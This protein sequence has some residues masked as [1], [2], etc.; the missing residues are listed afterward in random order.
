MSADSNSLESPAGEPAGARSAP[1]AAPAPLLDKEGRNLPKP[2]Q[3]A[4][5]SKKQWM[6]RRVVLD[7]LQFWQ[8]SGYQ[9]L[10]V[11]L[12][13]SPSSPVAR[14]RA[15]FQ[16]LRKRCGRELGFPGFQYVCVDTREGHGVLH[17]LWAWRDPDGKK[18]ASFYV[19]FAWLQENWKDIHGAFHV[20][21]KRVGGQDTDAKRLSRYIV[22]QYCGGQDAL[23]RVSQ[24][25]R[26][27]PFS[28]MRVALRRL[29]RELPE[30]HA[31]NGRLLEIYRRELSCDWEPSYGRATR[32]ALARIVWSS[33]LR[34][35]FWVEF[36]ECWNMLTRYR[37]FIPVGYGHEQF[38]WVDGGLER[39]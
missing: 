28:A 2:S 14:L 21:V 34:A 26:Q 17:M 4:R 3:Y 36:R 13:S 39:V 37:S 35:W 29:L 6:T 38:V 30:R 10:W 18:R 22:S 16:V 32:E 12:T 31:Y 7:Q 20:N 24:S 9:V 5:W 11:T 19:P 23:V 27:F 1:L 8:G 25:R 33:Q 15:D